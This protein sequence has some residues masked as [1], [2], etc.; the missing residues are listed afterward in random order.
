MTEDDRRSCTRHL[1]RSIA[2]TQQVVG[3]LEEVVQ[4][5]ADHRFASVEVVQFADPQTSEP[6]WVGVVWLLPSDDDEALRQK[7]WSA[8]HESLPGVWFGRLVLQVR[9][10]GSGH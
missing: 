6:F 2:P 1:P 7:V 3:R 10:A 8:V 4:A 9:G 5:T